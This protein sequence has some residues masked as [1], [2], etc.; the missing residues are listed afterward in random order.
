MRIA[1]ALLTI[2]FLS[3]PAFAQTSADEKAIREA[4]AKADTTGQR[5]FTKDRIFWSAA[6]KR[7]FVGEEQG[8]ESPDPGTTFAE[9]K[10]GSQRTKTTVKRIEIAK[11]GDLAYEYSDTELSFDLKN[12]RHV[13][14]PS[15]T[16]RA[17]RKEAGQWKI[18][19]LFQ[20]LIEKE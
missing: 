10:D 17:W 7:P 6:Y 11:S 5:P 12:G 9:R 19:A 3:S 13:V 14:L 1:I 8:V 2:S 16:L 18:A 20:P 15:A 4:I